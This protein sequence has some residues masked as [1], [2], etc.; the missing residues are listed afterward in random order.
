MLDE[1]NKGEENPRPNLVIRGL[2]KS[3]GGAQ[4]LSNVNLTVNHGEIHGLLG[5]NGSGKST[6]IKILSGFHEPDGDGTIELGG[7]QINLPIQPN[8]SAEYGISIVHQTLGLVPS[9]SVTENLFVDQLVRKTNWSI[10]WSKARRE[11]KNI[12]HRYELDIHPDTLISDLPPVERA[13]IAI[14]RAFYELDNI[15]QSEGK[16]LIL[17]EPTPFLSAADVERLFSLVR[18]VAQRGVSVIFVSHDIDEIKSL[19]Q[20]ATVLRNGKVAANLVTSTSN[21]KEFIKAIVGR[22]VEFEHRSIGQSSGAAAVAIKE[23]ISPGLAPFSLEVKKGEVIGLTGLL[24]SG[25]EKVPYLVYGAHPA[26]GGSLTLNGQKISVASQ[27]SAQAIEQG[28]VLIP[29]DRQ[30]DGIVSDFSVAENLA[31]PVL[32]KKL[33]HWN[34]RHKSLTMNAEPLVRDYDIRPADSSLPLKALSGGNQQK[35]VIAKWLQT[36]PDLILLDEPTQGVDVGARDQIFRLILKAARAGACV[37]CAS[38]DHEQLA[39]ICDR[40]LIFARGRVIAE[41]SSDQVTKEQIT[42][43]CF[44]SLD[45]EVSRS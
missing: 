35:V 37:I 10:G 45:A 23:L 33:S 4:A 20:R 5:Q 40:V 14:I 25:Y 11:A 6:L 32:G 36:D 28:I 43:S 34:V 27:S 18:S 21:K 38:S 9:L 22:D 8:Q 19:T 29:A 26:Q 7:R 42:E 13:L 3:F 12:L 2:S 16:L 17:D 31:L 30:K 39:A 24:G 1:K 15:D 41:L 44:L